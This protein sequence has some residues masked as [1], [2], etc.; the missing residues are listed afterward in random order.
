MYGPPRVA[1]CVERYACGRFHHCIACTIGF[2][3]LQQ[4][5]H[6]R[7]RYRAQCACLVCEALEAPLKRIRIRL[8]ACLH[9]L[10]HVARGEIH[11]QIFLQRDLALGL[12]IGGQVGHTEGAFAQH[13]FNAKCIEQMA[14]A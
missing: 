7:V 5:D 1:P 3:V 4:T 12:R 2:E 14:R 8:G 11:R 10:I 13:R 9:A 6:I